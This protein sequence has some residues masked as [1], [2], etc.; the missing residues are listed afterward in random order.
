[1]ALDTGTFAPGSLSDDTGAGNTCDT[2]NDPVGCIFTEDLLVLDATE[3]EIAAAVAGVSASSGTV[4]TSSAVAPPPAASSTA[5]VLTADCT[6]LTT[7]VTMMMTETSGAAITSSAAT[8]AVSGTLHF[9]DSSPWPPDLLT[10]TGANIQ[11]FTGTLG[12]PPP[13]VVSSAGNRPFSVNGNTFVNSG[14]ALQRS[15]SIQHNACADAANS[16]NLAGGVGQ[17]DTQEN[18]CNALIPSKVKRA[19]LDFGSCTDP[20]ILFEFGLDGRT[21][22]AFI[23]SNQVDFNHGSALNIGVI[24]SFICQRLESPCNAAADA[25]A[26]CSAG[27][28]AAAGKSYRTLNPIPAWAKLWCLQLKLVKQLRTLSMQL[29]VSQELPQQLLPS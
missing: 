19:A 20:S 9:R 27:E 3:D 6:A 8:V 22:E 11:T 21:E 16:G 18:A 24:A 1:V 5:A 4:S 29:L 28:T 12:G 15:C 2:Q 13:P 26:A 25:I 23:A 17:C 7:T 10:S 14:A